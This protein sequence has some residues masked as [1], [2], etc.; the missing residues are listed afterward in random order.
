MSQSAIEFE[1]L[2]VD[3]E[4]RDIPGYPGYQASNLGRIRSSVFGSYKILSPNA[5]IKGYLAV[6]ING[7]GKKFIHRL[8]L[9][10]FVG[11]PKINEQGDHI[12]RIK[13]DNRLVNLRWISKSANLANRSNWGESKYYGVHFKKQ[14]K[15]RKD[16]SLYFGISIR[17][18]IRINHKIV[19]LGTFKTEEEAHEAY[20]KAYRNHYGYEW[21]Q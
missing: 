10:T 13:T 5:T 19:A 9:L 11:E 15:V 8:V 18:Q 17:S 6:K 14:K 20:K 1:D 2:H 3:E 12:N 4:W 7:I 21:Q 16:G